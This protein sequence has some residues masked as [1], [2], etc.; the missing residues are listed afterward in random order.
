[1]ATQLYHSLIKSTNA[2]CAVIFIRYL[3]TLPLS[4]QLQEPHDVVLE[5]G[6]ALLEE[7][8]LAQHGDELVR[9]PVRNLLPQGV[10]VVLDVDAPE[11]DGGLADGDLLRRNWPHP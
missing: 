4:F 2:C 11:A 7:G 6:V 10:V 3:C 8:L 9:Q 1:M 5:L